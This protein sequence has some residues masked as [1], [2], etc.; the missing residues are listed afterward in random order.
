MNR[1]N[2]S[3]LNENEGRLTSFFT[4]RFGSLFLPSHNLDHH[5][6]VWIY[7]VGIVSQLRAN[8][9]QFSNDFLSGLQIA[10]LTHDIGLATDRGEA[11]GKA[12]R[13]VAAKYG[14]L[15]YLPPSVQDEVLFAIENHDRKDYIRVSP[16]E[17]MLTILSVA[18]DLDALGYIGVYRYIEIYLERGTPPAIISE[19]VTQNLS[20]RYMHLSKVY[21]FLPEFIDRHTSR[22]ETARDFFNPEGPF[23]TSARSKI[24]EIIGEKLLKN[25]KDITAIAAEHKSDLNSDI[26]QFFGCLHKELLMAEYV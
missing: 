15:A 10:S 3:V 16:P 5:L 9:F 2:E 17:S 23:S 21:G 7:A 12:S 18:D 6:R 4:E 26:A 8:G 25:H 22:Y 1:L 19:A 13:E 24:I 20:A 11:H 14:P